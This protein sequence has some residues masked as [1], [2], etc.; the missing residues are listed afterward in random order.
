M[1]LNALIVMVMV[2]SL[3]IIAVALEVKDVQ[4]VVDGVGE[5]ALFV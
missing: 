1:T 2:T 5:N 3:V 4:C